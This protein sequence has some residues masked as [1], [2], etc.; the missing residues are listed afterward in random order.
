M[1]E[2]RKT[3]FESVLSKL[4]LEKGVATYNEL[5]AQTGVKD[6][7]TLENW[8]NELGSYVINKGTGRTETTVRLKGG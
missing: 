5:K 3:T 1:N 7:R 4:I 2:T 6:N 8:I